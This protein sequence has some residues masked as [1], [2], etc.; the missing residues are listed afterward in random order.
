VRRDTDIPVALDRGC[1]WHDGI[2]RT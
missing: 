1:A 2:P